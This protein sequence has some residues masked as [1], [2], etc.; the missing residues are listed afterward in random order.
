MP[1]STVI[2]RRYR[3]KLLRGAVAPITLAIAMGPAPPAAAQ[4]VVFDPS[5][6]SQNILTAARA[7]QQ[8]NNQIRILGNQSLLLINSSRNVISLPTSIAG[9]LKTNIDDINRLM[10]QAQG[11]SFEVDATTAQFQNRYPRQYSAATSS[12]RMM[13]DATA[14][15]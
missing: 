5:N 10:R 12:D 8:I 1:Q 3:M 15:W 6:Y 14:R 2:A 11:I 13:Q 4:A 7:L 9:Q